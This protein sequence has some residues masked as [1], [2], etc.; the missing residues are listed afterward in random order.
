MNV[1]RLR[2][3]HMGREARVKKDRTIRSSGAKVTATAAEL[4]GGN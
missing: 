2:R 1:E 4:K 3:A